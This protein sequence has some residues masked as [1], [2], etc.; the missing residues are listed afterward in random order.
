MGECRGPLVRTDGIAPGGEANDH[1]TR[2]TPGSMLAARQP[3]ILRVLASFIEGVGQ[4]KD[5]AYEFLRFFR[6]A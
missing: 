1:L 2:R 6:R 5:V 4:D 3:S